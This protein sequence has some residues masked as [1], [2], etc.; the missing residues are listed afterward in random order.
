MA[1]SECQYSLGSRDRCL[2]RSVRRHARTRLGCHMEDVRAFEVG[3]VEC[4]DV[5]GVQ[6]HRRVPGDV[7]RSLGETMW[8][9]G[10]HDCL[11]AQVQS[12]VRLE[13]ALQHPAAKETRPASHEQ[14]TCAQVLP[15]ALSVLQD[16]LE[17]LI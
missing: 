9:S 2:E 10:Q 3:E 12:V 1:S 17:I 16:V 6:C 7:G 8:I 14:S 11:G 5:A 15:N 4:L 13:E